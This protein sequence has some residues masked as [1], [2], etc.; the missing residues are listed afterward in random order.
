MHGIPNR[1]HISV[2]IR[3]YINPVNAVCFPCPDGSKPSIWMYVWN[4]E[5]MSSCEESEELV[6]DAY[7]VFTETLGDA[8]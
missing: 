6:L 1:L 5:G 4:S 7:V 8:I 2:T 3:T